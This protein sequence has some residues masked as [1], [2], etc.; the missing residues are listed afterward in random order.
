[1][2]HNIELTRIDVMCCSLSSAPSSSNMRTAARQSKVM[3]TTR[4]YLSTVRH[5]SPSCP[6]LSL[7]FV[8]LYHSDGGDGRKKNS[9][10]VAFAETMD[11][12]TAGKRIRLLLESNTI[13]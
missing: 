7:Q 10:A 5:G 12:E 6:F 8:R 4:P 9:I 1:M 2:H 13:N 3:P 11:K